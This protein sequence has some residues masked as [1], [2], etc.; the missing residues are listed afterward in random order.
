MRL[1]K[2]DLI[3]EKDKLFVIEYILRNKEGKINE[4]QYKAYEVESYDGNKIIKGEPYF[5]FYI[6]DNC[7]FVKRTRPELLNKDIKHDYKI[8]QL[9]KASYTYNKYEVVAIEDNMI[10]IKE[11]NTYRKSPVMDFYIG[12]LMESEY[13]IIGM[14]PEIKVESEQER[15]RK[16]YYIEK[17]RQREEQE[18]LDRWERRSWA[19]YYEPLEIFGTNY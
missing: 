10:Y 9:L 4:K 6:N 19:G 12:E 17:E 5:C 18:S 11:Y 1:I 8:G 14:K 7:K 13:K 2:G 16:E 3:Q 15:K